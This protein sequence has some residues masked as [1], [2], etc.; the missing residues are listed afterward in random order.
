MRRPT[1]YA[2][3]PWNILEFDKFETINCEKN[4]QL[5]IVL[6]ISA[7]NIAIPF[8]AFYNASF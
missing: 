8:N 2:F 1:N 7:V 3:R 6:Q 4:T 5:Q